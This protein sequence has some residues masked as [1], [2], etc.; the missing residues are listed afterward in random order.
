MYFP[1]FMDMYAVDGLYKNLDRYATIGDY[2]KN[3]KSSDPFTIANDAMSRAPSS[4]PFVIAARALEIVKASA[5]HIGRDAEQKSKALPKIDSEP[6]INPFK[7]M[8][9]FESLDFNGIKKQEEKK[10]DP[11]KKPK[12]DEKLH[13]HPKYTYRLYE[14]GRYEKIHKNNSRYNSSPSIN[15]SKPKD[16]FLRLLLK[17][18]YNPNEETSR[19]EQD[20]THLSNLDYALISIA[21][22]KQTNPLYPTASILTSAGSY[23]KNATDKYQNSANM[24]YNQ[25]QITPNPHINPSLDGV[26]LKIHYYQE[27]RNNDQNSRII[28]KFPDSGLEKILAA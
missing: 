24:G 8:Y 26:I 19:F 10:Y 25:S 28:I 4:N 9:G 22:Y 15:K 17:S 1:Q 3:R 2:A 12:L 16:Y 27:R 21:S 13:N 20:T 6:D 23:G 7:Q 11:F 18:T 14:D 5:A